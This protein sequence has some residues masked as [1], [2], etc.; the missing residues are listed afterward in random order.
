MTMVLKICWIISILFSHINAF[1]IPNK[2]YAKSLGRIQRGGFY[3]ASSDQDDYSSSSETSDDDEDSVIVDVVT[4]SFSDRMANQAKP[5]SMVSMESESRSQQSRSYFLCGALYSSLALDAILNKKKRLAIFPGL[6]NG[7]LSFDTIAPTAMLASGFI[8]SAGLAWILSYSL[9]TKDG[10][11]NFDDEIQNEATRRKLHLLLFSFGIMNLF[12]NL[13]ASSAPFFGMGGFIINTH[14]LLIALSGWIKES[15][16]GLNSK[17]KD[18][19]HTLIDTFKCMFRPADL[20]LEFKGRMMSSLYMTGSIV[21]FLR[22]FGMLKNV[23]IPHYMTCFLSKSLSVAPLPVLQTIGL[24]WAELSRTLLAGG[25]CMVLKEEVDSRRGG[26]SLAKSLT[27]LL[28]TS[29]I[30]AGIPGVLFG[31]VQ[32]FSSSLKLLIFAMLSGLS[33][34]I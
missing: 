30:A 28:T 34:L 6:S 19:T 4:S 20:T 12:S 9:N 11:V 24:Q 33:L 15:N 27:A 2:T 8:L 32:Y 31:G 10:D 25:L 7:R 14:N 16:S 1:I 18:M 3:Q 29:A 13:N 21:A 26:K 5:M 23:L 17:V 22:G